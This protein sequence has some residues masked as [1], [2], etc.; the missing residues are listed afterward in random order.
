MNQPNQIITKVN[1]ENLISQWRELVTKEREQA[2]LQLFPQL[3]AYI[4]QIYS[5]EAAYVLNPV[6][7]PYAN[8]SFVALNNALKQEYGL[9]FKTPD[10][11]R[12][13]SLQLLRI[14]QTTEELG[15]MLLSL[16][17]PQLE[18]ENGLLI[19]AD[20]RAIKIQSVA[21]SGEM[22][23]AKVSGATK[24]AEQVI[25]ELVPLL[26]ALA[27]VYQPWS[28]ICK[29]HQ[30]ATYGTGTRVK[31]PD[32]GLGFLSPAF[33]ATLN[34]LV[35]PNKGLALSMGRRD[36]LHEWV[37]PE[38][39]S[40]KFTLDELQILFHRNEPTGNFETCR[41]RIGVNARHERGTGV[42]A[43]DS[44]L[45]LDEHLTLVEQIIEAVKKVT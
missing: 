40:A 29:Y 41:L 33:T 13:Q 45:P 25:Y 6:A 36:A 7:L 42:M 43:V 38:G 1:A 32:Q 28:E 39:S 24:A 10:L 2:A 14:P 5:C 20:R 31:F 3:P 23:F 9:Q 35:S 27:G 12:L 18:F 16:K 8:I 37:T 19:T 44:E 30:V 22:V 11:G 26:W 15:Q 34:N 21:L 17:D 4:V